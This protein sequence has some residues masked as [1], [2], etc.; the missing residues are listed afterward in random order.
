MKRKTKYIHAHVEIIHVRMN[1][2]LTSANRKNKLSSSPLAKQRVIVEF[3][4]VY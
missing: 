1:S 4:S 3:Y 2:A